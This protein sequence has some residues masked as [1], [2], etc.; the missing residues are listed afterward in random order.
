MQQEN[1]QVVEDLCQ[2]WQGRFKTAVSGREWLDFTTG[3]KGLGIQAVR[4]AFGFSKEEIAVFGDN[5]NDVEMLEEAGHSYAMD[6]AAEAVKAH[7]GHV[8]SRVEDVLR[9]IL[10][11]LQ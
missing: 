11:T 2:R 6:T 1:P 7:A 3:H 5:Y 4:E 8:C 9:E 10:D